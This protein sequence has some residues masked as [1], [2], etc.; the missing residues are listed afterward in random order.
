[1]LTNSEMTIRVGLLELPE[2][3]INRIKDTTRFVIIPTVCFEYRRPQYFNYK[4]KIWFRFGLWII[5]IGI[6]HIQKRSGPIQWR[7]TR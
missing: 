7:L 5:G 6:K 1:M 4:Y 3:R 2:K